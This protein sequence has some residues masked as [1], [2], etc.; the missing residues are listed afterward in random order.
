M[1]NIFLIT[2]D[3]LF[4]RERELN[5]IK[6][7]F[8]ELVKGINF[9]TLDKDTIHLLTS[10]VTTYPFGFDKKLIHLIN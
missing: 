8:G 10:E 7:N 1:E 6:N 2:G 9:I 4:E 5:N 3:D